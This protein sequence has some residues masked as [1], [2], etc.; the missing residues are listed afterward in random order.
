MSLLLARVEPAAT[1]RTG[2]GPFSRL[3]LYGGP[4][5]LYGS[6]DRTGLLALEVTDAWSVS[7]ADS[8]TA[9]DYIAP[10]VDD[11]NS[12]GFYFAALRLSRAR[13]ARIE[14]ERREAEEKR[15]IEDAIARQI[16]E[17][18]QQA[19]E[20]EARLAE[21]ERLRDI[22]K[23]YAEDIASNERLNRALTRALEKQTESSWL[24]LMREAERADDDDLMVA[25]L[26]ADD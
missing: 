23:Q 15:A 12:G 20:A 5:R 14:R 19:A 3:G 25:L 11:A 17:L 6:F 4:Q 16:A 1:D 13:Q 7:V 2:L 9:E 26:L 18:M 10:V 8:A 21:A 24:A 22:A